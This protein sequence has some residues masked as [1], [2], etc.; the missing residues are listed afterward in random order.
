VAAGRGL[1]YDLCMITRICPHC[2]VT[3]HFNYRWSGD[4]FDEDDGGRLA[5][6][7]FAWQCDNCQVPVCGVYGEDAEAGEETVWPAVVVRPTYPTYQTP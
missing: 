7:A 2:L 3:S 1:T 5:F 4:V 6:T